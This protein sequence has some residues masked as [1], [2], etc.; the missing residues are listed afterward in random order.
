MVP[1]AGYPTTIKTL[2][3]WELRALPVHR[4]A[5]IFPAL[6]GDDRKRLLATMKARYDEAQPIIVWSR[7]GELIDGRNRRDLAVTVLK[8]SALPVA[9]VDFPDEEAIRLY[10]IQANLARRHL[11]DSRERRELAGRLVNGHGMSTREAA[12]LAGVSQKTAH[13]AAVSGAGESYDSP[14]G[15]PDGTPAERRVG[16][17]GKAYP[18]RQSNRQ[19]GRQPDFTS[20]GIIGHLEQ[21]AKE[22][23]ELLADASLTPAALRMIEQAVDVIVAKL[24]LARGGGAA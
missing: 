6:K 9:F 7:T 11:L 19:P 14:G 13:R 4:Y 2:T 22:L 10:V 3:A 5:G 1:V 21:A 15:A 24:G 20:L 12:R 23:D 17:D 8:L 16:H 18:A